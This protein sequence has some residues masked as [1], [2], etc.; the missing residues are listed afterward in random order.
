[1]TKQM[2]ELE[3]LI[4][5]KVSTDKAWAIR[6]IKVLSTYQTS[7]EFAESETRDKNH[8]GFNGVD[9]PI[10]TSFAKWLQRMTS[11]TE[12]QFAVAFKLLPKYSGQ[13]AR[14]SE[15]KANKKGFSYKK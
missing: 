7:D 14:I 12:K 6:A 5:E 1:M 13:L 8:V 3:K 10:L 11:L 4:R 2:I 9:A 15:E